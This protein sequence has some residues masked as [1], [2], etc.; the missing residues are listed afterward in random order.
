MLY[1]T[2]GFLEWYESDDSQQPRFAPLLTLPVTLERAGGGKGAEFHCTVEY[3]GDDLSTNLSLAEKLRRDF[4]LEMP[5]LA[6]EDTPDSYFAK[7][8]NLLKQ[9]PRWKIRRQLTL[10]LLSFGKLLMYLDLDPKTWQAG[11]A[12]SAHPI[13]Q[14]LFEGK[15][16]EE[17]SH[18]EEYPIDDPVLKPEV[19][20]LIM[21]ADSSQHSA[22]IH[23]LKGQNLVIEGPPG[24]GKSQTIT[25]LIAAALVKGK[26][27]LFVLSN[28][29]STFSAN[30]ASRSIRRGFSF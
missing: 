19:P 24:T 28:R 17:I 16:S 12:I 26:T 5:S 6:D 27:V 30:F 2:F 4:G 14:E 7:F 8:G 9:K 25:N 22:L 15:K 10:S 21:D 13:V 29:D 3:S 11:T 1:L 23:A 18:A 20:N